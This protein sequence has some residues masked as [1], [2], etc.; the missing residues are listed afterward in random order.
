MDVTANPEPLIS[1]G[2][3]DAETMS[4]M[5]TESELLDA[6][7]SSGDERAELSS[8]DLPDPVSPESPTPSFEITNPLDAFRATAIR[9]SG[10]IDYLVP[11]KGSKLPSGQ[12]AAVLGYMPQMLTSAYSKQQP[13]LQAVQ[14][15]LSKFQSSGC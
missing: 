15:Q 3:D 14:E 7:S 2:A 12:A 6:I 8:S 13:S 10:L 1:T 5:I 9:S 11:G 4:G